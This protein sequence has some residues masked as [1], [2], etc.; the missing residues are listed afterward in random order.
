MTTIAEQ[1]DVPEA[2]INKKVALDQASG[3]IVSVIRQE[4][5]KFTI[6]TI[7]IEADDDEEPPPTAGGEATN[8]GEAIA[9]A[10]WFKQALAELERDVREIKGSGD[11]PQIV[12]YHHSTNLDKNA[13]K[14]D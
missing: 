9:D 10:P 11:N 4:N 13:A 5:G 3:G 7:F 1:I 12:E 2:K 6:R 8:T 14:E